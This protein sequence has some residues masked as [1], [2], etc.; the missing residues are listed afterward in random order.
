MRNPSPPTS[1]EATAGASSG[2]PTANTVP[3]ESRRHQ[4]ALSTRGSK[5]SK[6]SIATLLSVTLTM[7]LLSLLQ[8]MK[9]RLRRKARSLRGAARRHLK[10]R[11]QHHH[12]HQYHRDDR[13]TNPPY[14]QSSRTN[15]LTLMDGMTENA[16][17]LTQSHAYYCSLPIAVA[18]S[19]DHEPIQYK[20]LHTIDSDRQSSPPRSLAIPNLES[21]HFLSVPNLYSSRNVAWSL[22]DGHLPNAQT[23]DD[24][25]AA[26][27]TQTQWSLA[28]GPGELSPEQAN[29]A[30]R[31]S[32]DNIHQMEERHHQQPYPSQDLQYRFDSQHTIITPN[33]VQ[34]EPRQEHRASQ[35]INEPYEG[36]TSSSSQPSPNLLPARQIS[37]TFDH[38]QRTHNNHHYHHHQPTP[39]SFV[40]WQDQRHYQIQPQPQPHYRYHQQIPPRFSHLQDH[41]DHHGQAHPHRQYQATRSEHSSRSGH[42]RSLS[43]TQTTSSRNQYAEQA[44]PV[45]PKFEDL[46]PAEQARQEYS[47]R[48]QRYQ[49]HQQYLQQQRHQQEEHQFHS[50][51]YHFHRKVLPHRYHYHV[52]H[53]HAAAIS[54]HDL[55][56]Y[57]TAYHSQKGRTANELAWER[58]CYYQQQQL[59]EEALVERKRKE[60]QWQQQQQQQQQQQLQQQE[61]QQQQ[62][63]QQGGLCPPEQDPFARTS[64]LNRITSSSLSPRTAQALGLSQSQAVSVCCDSR[65]PKEIKV[66]KTKA[67]VGTAKEAGAAK[68]IVSDCPILSA[69]LRLI[70]RNEAKDLKERDS[71]HTSNNED[72][73][74]SLDS[75]QPVVLQPQESVTP[76]SRRR[77][78]KSIAPS[79]RSLARRCSSRFGNRPNSFA[80]SSSDPN[81]QFTDEKT[82][83]A[84]LAMETVYAARSLAPGLDGVVDLQQVG[85]ADGDSAVK[86]CPPISASTSFLPLKA[87][88]SERIPV[89]RKVTLFRSKTTTISRSSRPMHDPQHNETTPS[90]A[91]PTDAMTTTK[92]T[93]L[94]ARP[95][96]S[97][98]LANGRGHELSSL[99]PRAP[100]EKIEQSTN[101]LN[102]ALPT[103][104]ISSAFDVEQQEATRRQVIALL[105]MG[106]K[107]RV[108]AKTGLTMV[109]PLLPSPKQLSPLALEAQDDIHAPLDQTQ[110]D[111]CERIAF[112]LVPK[113]RYEFQPLVMA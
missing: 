38:H 104:V 71:T 44:V 103:D 55:G 90:S 76:L 30:W 75:L 109:Q 106:R 50:Q 48:R 74:A 6:S 36:S 33:G 102:S 98:R 85:P 79:I 23:K 35:L 12:H 68:S 32:S 94:S 86:Y 53:G 26:W 11:H 60:A 14:S 97:L 39:Y 70:K 87:A 62:G 49:M 99:Q 57:P 107:E 101:D 100:A 111:P 61:G 66:A 93:T 64:S 47:L 112:M 37:A 84:S 110:E 81:I 82:A 22:S 13:S 108:S 10:S 4:D 3:V 77:T 8:S 21:N 92:T 51:E 31:M 45:S 105:A 89:H 56:R 113:S 29:A 18:N 67:S 2:L 83:S 1:K 69:G 73:P 63:Q 88:A 52:H 5:V 15:T 7:I 91:A 58:H 19:A 80:G 95:R 43:L 72:T 20:L 16:Q 65:K 25:V 46:S 40:Q 78:L 28:I 42:R 54:A 59:Q 96:D 9:R 24:F 41:S 27:L 34:Q 17:S